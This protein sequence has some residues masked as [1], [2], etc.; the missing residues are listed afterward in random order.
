MLGY[1]LKNGTRGNENAVEAW[2][3]LVDAATSKL[4][5]EG[6]GPG[7]MTYGY[8]GARIGFIGSYCG[9]LAI[10]P[11]RKIFRFCDGKKLAY[12][13]ALVVR[14]DTGL[15][16]WDYEAS[17]EDLRKFQIEALEYDWS[18]VRQPKALDF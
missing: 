8:L 7:V 2:K 11:V 12:L 1:C 3:I 10:P 4:D 9:L 13:S 17:E 14:K 5:L 18:S 6:F 16:G 15:P